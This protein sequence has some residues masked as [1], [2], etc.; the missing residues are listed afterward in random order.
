MGVATKIIHLICQIRFWRQR[1]PTFIAVID[2]D[3][4]NFSANTRYDSTG[5]FFQ[6]EHEKSHSQTDGARAI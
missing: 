4:R 6:H 5:D 1:W 2:K 3:G